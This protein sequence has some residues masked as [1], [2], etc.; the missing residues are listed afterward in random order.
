MFAPT[1]TSPVTIPRYCR[2]GRPSI[3]GVVVTITPRASFHGPAIDLL[4]RSAQ[5][6]SGLVGF[7]HHFHFRAVVGLHLSEADDLA[8]DL[9]VIADRLDRKSTRLNSSH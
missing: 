5:P 7:E 1:I 6:Q 2:T 9:G 3:M 8:H 4:L